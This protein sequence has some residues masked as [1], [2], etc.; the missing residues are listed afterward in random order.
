MAL[1]R[2]LRESHPGV[3]LS[4]DSP[5]LASRAEA[6]VKSEGPCAVISF[7]TSF[8]HFSSRKRSDPPRFT[9]GSWA[10]EG[11]VGLEAV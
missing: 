11:E 7:I 9:P 4:E 6:G 10:E 8:T 2:C 1:G 3:M 5:K